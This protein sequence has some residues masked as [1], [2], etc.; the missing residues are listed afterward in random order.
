MKKLVVV[1]LVLPLVALSQ[2]KIVLSSQRF[3]P[4]TDKNAEFE[5]GLAAHAQKYHTGLWKWRVFE[6]ESGPDFGAVMIVEGPNTWDDFDKRGDLGADH[7]NDWNKNVAPYIENHAESFYMEYKEQLS[8]IPLT[9]YSKWVSILHLCP[10]PGYVAATEELIGSMKK[11]WTDGKESVVV[12]NAVSSGD[13][14]YTV[15]TRYKQGLKEKDP[16]FLSGTL[17]ERY[18]KANGDG[19]FDKFI[20]TFRSAIHKQWSELLMFREDLSSK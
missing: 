20:E 18:I 19:S 10:N 8:T 3:F 5:K 9:D 4:K 6:I 12:Y 2:A 7:L 13:P 14:Q 11:V 1:L 15:V 17:K 16:G